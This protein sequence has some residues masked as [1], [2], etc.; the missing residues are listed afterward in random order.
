MLQKF[1]RNV[2]I[3]ER[4]KLHVSLKINSSSLLITIDNHW[5]RVFLHLICKFLYFNHF[6]ELNSYTHKLLK[7]MHDIHLKKYGSTLIKNMYNL[8]KYKSFGITRAHFLHIISLNNL[9]LPCLHIGITYCS[10]NKTL[11]C[12]SQ[13]VMVSTETTLTFISRTCCLYLQV[14]YL[15]SYQEN[16]CNWRS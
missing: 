14:C 9:W 2:F 12:S 1:S 4:N 5:Y 6:N 11:H 10:H 7:K 8:C 15:F 13:K 16:N 3:I